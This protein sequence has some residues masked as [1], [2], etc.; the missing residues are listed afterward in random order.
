LKI[1]LEEKSRRMIQR[2]MICWVLLQLRF[3]RIVR[4]FVVKKKA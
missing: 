2:K 1:I 3:R 4:R